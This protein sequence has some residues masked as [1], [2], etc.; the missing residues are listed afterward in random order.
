MTSSS[1]KAAVAA[2]AVAIGAYWYWSPV[3]A[4]HQMQ[5]AA[6]AGDADAF[7]DHVDYPRLRESVK[8]QFSAMLTKTLSSQPESGNDFAKAGAAFGTMLGLAM[9]D[10]F[11][12]AMVRP[13]VVM[14]AMQ[15]GKLAPK[16]DE[17][18]SA[19]S[20]TD[21][22]DQVKWTSERKSVDKYIAYAGRMG[23]ADDKRVAMVLERTGFANWKLTEVRLPLGN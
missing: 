2:A 19:P 4:I 8:G 21:P 7:N 15:E 12:D 14:R 9:V 16:K 10:R 11:V 5:T 1:I 3:L 18:A 22:A 13:E 6:K 17:P 23:D 20:S